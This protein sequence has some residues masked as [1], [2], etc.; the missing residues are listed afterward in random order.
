MIPEDRSR[1]RR[2]PPFARRVALA[3]ALLL[4]ALARPA[5]GLELEARERDG[6]RVF[7]AGESPS[8]GEIEARIGREGSV[9]PGSAA[10]C[11]SCHGADGLGRPEGG[12]V[13][14]EVTWTALT[15]PYGHAHPGGRSHPAFDE[16]T[17]ARAV[18]EGRDPA[19]NP[20]DPV[21]PRYRISD[22]DLASLLA[23]LRVVD[24][25][26]DPGIEPAAVRLGVVLPDRGR[27]AETG[28]G[29]LRLLRARADER[30]RLGGVH[31]RRLELVV[32][33]YDS[34]A[35]DG[36]AEAERLVAGGE[37]FALVSGL[38]PGAE[39]AVATAAEE[40]KV[41]VVGPFTL[42]ARQADPPN[43]WVFHLQSGPREQ[44]R[45]LAA[46]AVRDLALDP[47]RIAV[48]R[49]DD[50]RAA[51]AA[52]GAREELGKA[53]AA[54]R[55]VTWAGAVPDAD[56]VRALAATGVRAVLFLG[57]D[58]A[59]EAFTRA[60]T[61]IGF[62][63]WL[64]AP[65]TLASRAAAR[66]PAAFRGRIRLAFPGSPADESAEGAAGLSRLREAAGLPDRNRT[67]QVAALVA[68][69]VLVEGLRRS[70]RQLSRE[71][72]VAALEGLYDF[73]TGLTHPLTYGPVRRIGALGGWI[74][75]P[76]GAKGSLATVGP[77]RSL[78]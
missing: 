54:L 57:G 63:P 59:L 38:F 37:V 34:D 58:A 48:V 72:F 31:G 18:R 39:D 4:A 7:L 76:D 14:T 55:E 46:H 2:S 53:G 8:G 44:A 70:G 64:L 12:V 51:D 5:P 47:A 19:G 35:G 21:M 22:A 36:R 16:R 52:A 3:T 27:L 29:M 30:N 10:P 11:G 17:F 69:D 65:G 50:P 9:L 62:T 41:P 33:G 71:R 74:V 49:P 32:A 66:A 75:E 25:D 68:L 67:S 23:Y 73:P 40:R 26:L 13:P 6:K 28:A 60:A 1:C 42:L 15:K 77:W 20:L 61:G 45:L 43:P 56:R 24:R 78:E